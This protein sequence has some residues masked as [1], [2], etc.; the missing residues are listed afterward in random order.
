MNT[1]TLHYLLTC[2][3]KEKPD[4]SVMF[5]L[6]T[7]AIMSLFHDLVLS[8]ISLFCYCVNYALSVTAHVISGQPH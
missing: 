1:L 2:R 4:V 5:T 3:D 6:L 7:E 8:F